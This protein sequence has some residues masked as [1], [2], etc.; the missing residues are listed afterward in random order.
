VT[1]PLGREYDDEAALYDELPDLTEPSDSES[2]I[3]GAMAKV[4]LDSNDDDYWFD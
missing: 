3:S 1:A 2:D 4:A